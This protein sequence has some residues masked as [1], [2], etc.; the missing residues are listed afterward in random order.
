MI[1]VDT[2]VLVDHLR[3]RP[4]ARAALSRS[5]TAGQLLVGSVLTKV[6]L[7]AGMRSDERGPTRALFSALE[8]LPVT[9]GIADHAGA[10]ARQYR[11]CQPAIDVVDYVL[12]ATAQSCGAEIWTLNVK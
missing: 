12:A 5:V 10:L 4:E 6:E 11:Q 9:E 8:W 2:S 3:G 1:L 7:L